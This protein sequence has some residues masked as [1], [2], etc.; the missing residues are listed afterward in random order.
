MIARWIAIIGAVSTLSAAGGVTGAKQAH[1]PATVQSLS[2]NIPQNVKQAI[3]DSL[4]ASDRPTTDDKQGGFHEEGGI[5]VTTTNGDVVAE[6]AVP[7]K[8][9]KRGDAAH[10]QVNELANPLPAARIAAVDGMWHVHPGGEIVDRRVLPA[11][12]EGDRKITT[13]ITTTWYFGQSPSEGDITAAELPINIAIGA[14]SKLVYFY[15]RS[16]IIGTMPL[17]EFLAPLQLLPAAPAAY[18]SRK[19]LQ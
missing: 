9:A 14:R 16:G 13:V 2:A 3:L 8:Y 5:F 12:E 11:R 4:K 17:E 10:V 1:Q 19:I 7:G 6:P 15:N 18:L